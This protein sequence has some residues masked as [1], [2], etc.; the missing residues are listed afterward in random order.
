MAI[1]VYRLCLPAAIRFFVT[2]FMINEN[3]S[4]DVWNVQKDIDGNFLLCSVLLW[5]ILIAFCIRCIEKELQIPIIFHYSIVYR[6][7]TKWTD[8]RQTVGRVK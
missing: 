3:Q 7:L 8:D 5:D 4:H 2:K 6:G 1:T